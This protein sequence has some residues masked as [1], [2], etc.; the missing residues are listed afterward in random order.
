MIEGSLLREIIEGFPIDMTA[1]RLEQSILY[2]LAEII[3]CLN[4][5]S[6]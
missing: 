5:N 3:A 6:F 4:E 2:H 1:A